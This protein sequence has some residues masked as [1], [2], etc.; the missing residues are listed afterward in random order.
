[1]STPSSVADAGEHALIAL[2]RERVPAAPSWLHLGIGDDAAVI[3]PARNRLDVVSTDALVEGVH[4][5]RDLMAP[6]DVGYR[7]LAVN[8]SDLAAMGATPRAALLSLALPAN[9]PLVEF[10]QLVDGL[11]AGARTFGVALA[12]GNITRSPGP[13][14]IDLTVLGSVRRRRVLTRSGARPGDQIWV[15]GLIGAAAAGL[16]ALKGGSR[17]SGLDA[18]I[19]A[20]LRPEPRLR[21]GQLLGRNRA[22]S[23]CVD[24]S[25]GLA[26]GLR[27]LAAASGVGVVIE[28]EALPI[29][30]EAG[31]LVHAGGTLV[32]RALCGG[33]DYELL[34]TVPARR[35]ARFE[36]VRR[37]V[38]GL[39]VTRIGSIT[40]GGSLVLRDQ[41]SERPIP[42]G[43]AHFR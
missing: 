32:D 17:P 19:R 9:L 21:L 27:Q 28:A 36:A 30:P 13:L 43:Y 6:A 10:E 2:I 40:S 11:L 29:P 39:R 41:E 33:D 24:L 38:H 4:F 3:E 14:V 37:L 15:S 25:D 23:A 42:A 34:F 20:F 16:Q 1:M 8:L 35:R 5:E 26:D 22:A 12:G 31:T 7:A 18:C